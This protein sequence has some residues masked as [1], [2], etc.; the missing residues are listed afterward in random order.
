MTD[1][2]ITTYADL[3]PTFIASVLQD[4]KAR[5]IPLIAKIPDIT[6]D[7]NNKDSSKRI[8][9]GVPDRFVVNV[10]KN[11]N[12]VVLHR[13]NKK[14]FLFINLPYEDLY[15]YSISFLPSKNL[16]KDSI[17]FISMFETDEIGDRI[18]HNF[19]QFIPTDF[20]SASLT[21]V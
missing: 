9:L 3:V 18:F 6:C 8:F 20:Q 11:P 21:T 17:F 13:I 12:L 19:I 10:S 7:S 5:N 1:N 15:S 2:H 4:Y 16:G 14:N